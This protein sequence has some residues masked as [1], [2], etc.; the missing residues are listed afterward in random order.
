MRDRLFAPLN[1]QNTLLP[2]IASDAIPEPYS[3]GHNSFMG[4]DPVNDATLVVWA[5]LAPA[6][7]G[8]DPATTI[9]ASLIGMLYP[10]AK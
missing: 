7:D 1:L 9:A 10:N 2:D 5:N 4:H 8:R 3:H 6:V